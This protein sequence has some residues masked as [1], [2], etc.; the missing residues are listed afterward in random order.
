MNKRLNGMSE[1]QLYEFLKA[2]RYPSTIE[3]IEELI[4]LMNTSKG[5]RRI[6]SSFIC[7]ASK[8]KAKLF[9][10]L[11]LKDLEYLPLNNKIHRLKLLC[12][13]GHN[14]SLEDLLNIFLN[15]PKT[16]NNHQSLSKILN[17]LLT[18]YLKQF[19]D[20]LRK[21]LHNKR[22]EVAYFA[23]KWTTSLFPEETLRRLIFLATSNDV[24]QHIREKVLIRISQ[25]YPEGLTEIILSQTFSYHIVLK[26]LQYFCASEDEDIDIDKQILK[27]FNSENES[28]KI[29]SSV[30]LLRT[31]N[32]EAS[33]VLYRE[34]VSEFNDEERNLEIGVNVKGQAIHYSAIE[35]AKFNERWVD[36]LISWAN[37]QKK[38]KIMKNI[39]L[40]AKHPKGMNILLEEIKNVNSVNKI[41]GPMVKGVNTYGHY[42][43]PI[44]RLALKKGDERI[45]AK[46]IEVWPKDYRSELFLIIESLK[47]DDTD[48]INKNDMSNKTEM[49][50][51]VPQ[52]E[53]NIDRYSNT[54]RTQRNRTI[55]E[56]IKRLEN[57]TCQTCKRRLIGRY[58]Q[59]YSEVHHIHPLGHGGDDQEDNMICLCP[60]CHRLFHLGLIGI[61]SQEEI[62]SPLKK[63]ETILDR[64]V[65]SKNRNINVESMRYHWVNIFLPPEDI[66][67]QDESEIE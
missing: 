55:V 47:V 7:R 50:S 21:L 32:Q 57:N 16:Q 6:V 45:K 3:D 53:E 41:F 10:P 35:L 20:T 15:D 52:T 39:L 17:N 27:I 4:P 2:K 51:I 28:Y 22:H 1:R 67:F 56:K 8:K 63:T 13:L 26:A 59:P 58:G 37:T 36:F 25:I 64:I 31:N 38:H 65:C 33:S 62:I 42:A 46:L 48:N 18:N 43:K 29:A 9:I 34:L 54:V 49:D 66:L 12:K 40:R 23:S 5:K 30:F 44:A 11:L 60:L 14:K 61:T 24:D 19:Q